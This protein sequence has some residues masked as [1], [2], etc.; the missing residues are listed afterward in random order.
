MERKEKEREE[1]E[2]RWRGGGRK[3]G[4]TLISGGG[5]NAN[6][7]IIVLLGPIVRH[8]VNRPEGLL[9]TMEERKVNL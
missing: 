4:S 7:N 3:E 1:E 2:A 5:Y 6:D 8:K 9:L